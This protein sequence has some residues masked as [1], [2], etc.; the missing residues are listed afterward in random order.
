MR[1]HLLATL[2]ATALVPAVGAYGDRGCDDKTTT[3]EIT[4]GS[5]ST[6]YYVEL[7]PFHDGGLWIYQESNGLWNPKPAGVYTGDDVEG[8]LQRGGASELI[9]DDSEICTEPNPAGP[10]YL[11][12]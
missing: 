11:V 8:D 7:P 10:D 12:I 6:T 4:D 5:A 3:I 2:L 9:P 1:T